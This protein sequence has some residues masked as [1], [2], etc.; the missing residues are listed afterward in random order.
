MTLEAPTA[1]KRVRVQSFALF[2]LDPGDEKTCSC[3]CSIIG[4]QSCIICQRQVFSA[5]AKLKKPACVRSFDLFL[6]STRFL[7]AGLKKAARAQL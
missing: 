5:P 4:A 1:K 6:L 2:C 3:V 7:A